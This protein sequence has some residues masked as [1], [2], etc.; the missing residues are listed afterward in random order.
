M[1]TATDSTGNELFT[2]DNPTTL[3]IVEGETGVK[4]YFE[5]IE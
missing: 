2:V 1:P 4:Y 3:T 5:A